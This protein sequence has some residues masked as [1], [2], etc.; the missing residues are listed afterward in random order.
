MLQRFHSGAPLGRQNG[1]AAAFKVARTIQNERLE[2]ETWDFLSLLT[3]SSIFSF[4][5]L[6]SSLSLPL[7]HKHAFNS[8]SFY[9]DMDFTITCQFH[10]VVDIDV[11]FFLYTHHFSIFSF[12]NLTSSLSLPFKTNIYL[13]RCI[14]TQIWVLTSPAGN[15]VLPKI[16]CILS[17]LV[18]ISVLFFLYTQILCGFLFCQSYISTISTP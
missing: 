11:L 17:L 12:A 16:Q 5:N 10:S 15:N 18:Y 4:A 13:I 7:Q 8:M 6:T 2:A 14:F 3:S 9:P 1:T